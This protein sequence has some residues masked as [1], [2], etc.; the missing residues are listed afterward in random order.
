M[1]RITRG[2]GRTFAALDAIEMLFYA[3]GGVLLLGAGIYFG[4]K[5]A[6]ERGGPVM[7]GILLGLLALAAAAIVRDVF[8]KR[9]GPASLALVVLWVLAVL[10]LI[11]SDAFA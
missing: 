2:I 5:A 8:R 9:W 10:I 11:V 4:F 6:L 7:A 3:L 1:G